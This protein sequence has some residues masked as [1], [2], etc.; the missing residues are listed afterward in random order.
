LLRRRAYS[1]PAFGWQVFLR[2]ATPVVAP[3]RSEATLR[4]GALLCC[5]AKPT[6]KGSKDSYNHIIP[7][8]HFIVIK[9]FR[10]RKQIVIKLFRE[11]KQAFLDLKYKE[12]K[13]IY[14]M[15]IK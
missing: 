8:K 10:E 3:L 14:L 2:T 4:T 11:R 7:F 5:E 13:C 15:N 9:L 12:I 6:S 1:H